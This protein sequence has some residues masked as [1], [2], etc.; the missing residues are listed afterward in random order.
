MSVGPGAVVV[1][2]H[3]NGLGAVR[4]LGERGV[5]VA[6]VCTKQADMA[7]ASRFAS[8][9]VRL[10]SFHAAPETLLDLL[11]ARRDDWRGRLLVPTNDEALELFSRHR[12]RLSADFR[13]PVPEWNRVRHVL[14]KG[15]TYAA[16]R[17][18]G[19]RVPEVYGTADCALLAR[20]DLPFPMLVKPRVSHTFAAR[21]GRKLL[22]ARDR[23]EFGVIVARLE[24][25]GMQAMAMELIP[26]PDSLGY[27][28]CVYID[29]RRRVRGTFVQRRLRQSPPF[30][31]VL[32]VGETCNER[33]LVE[34]TLA[35][36]REL[37]WTGVA[38]ANFKLD[39]GTG[40]FVLMEVNGR[41]YLS[42][43]LARRCGLDHVWLMYAEHALST[44]EDA[45]PN[46]WQGRWIHLYEDLHWSLGMRGVERLSLSESLAPYRGPKVF[47]VWSR[48]D[49][50]PFVWQ[51]RRGARLLLSKEGR[52]SAGSGDLF[53]R[54]ESMPV[55]ERK[56]P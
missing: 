33:R 52:G 38:T 47:A 24:E 54:V 26:G 35:L 44:P 9:A 11:D 10:P 51:W 45:R 53:R 7:H 36:L 42:H 14:D 31:G 34:P 27:G 46:G 17:R 28:Q 43:G 48:K 16:A 37:D 6:V 1:G 55:A 56:T 2:G 25:D 50:R 5:R 49:P 40:E 4:A 39:L 19:I 15:L 30:F 32:R 3:A 23:S 41:C 29:E 8:E 18:V 12:E 22:V 20:D 13:V 21:Y